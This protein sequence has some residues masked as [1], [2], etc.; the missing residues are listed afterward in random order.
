MYKGVCPAFPYLVKMKSLVL[1]IVFVLTLTVVCGQNKA[2]EAIVSP[3][4]STTFVQNAPMLY[5]VLFT[6][7]IKPRPQANLEAIAVLDIAAD[8]S[9]AGVNFHPFAGREQDMMG[10]ENMMGNLIGQQFELPDGQ[11][12]A[13]QYVLPVIIRYGDDNDRDYEDIPDDFGKMIRLLGKNPR[14]GIFPPVYIWFGK[15]TY[16]PSISSTISRRNTD[17]PFKSKAEDKNN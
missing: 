13:K 14:V 6:S 5:R 11:A 8:S 15:P 1:T 2:L 7:R 12:M 16:C 10:I 17:P 4:D 3:A 9:I